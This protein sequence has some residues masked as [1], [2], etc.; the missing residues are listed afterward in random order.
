MLLPSGFRFSDEVDVQPDD[1]ED[2]DMQY[3]AAASCRDG[4]QRGDGYSP[5]RQPATSHKRQAGSDSDMDEASSRR[6]YH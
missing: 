1:D 3:G 2:D 4:L 6:K 5:Q